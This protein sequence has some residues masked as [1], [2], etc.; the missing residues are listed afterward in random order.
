[1]I[2]GDDE[3]IAM[4]LEGDAPGTPEMHS[5]FRSESYGIL[6]TITFL[7]L[8]HD[9][10][11][12][13]WPANKKLHLYCDNKGLIQRLNNHLHSP[14]TPREYL[15]TDSDV[16]LQ[17]L[18]SFDALQQTGIHIRLFHVKGHQDNT[19]PYDELSRPAQLN[20]QAD[21]L[22][23]IQLKKKQRSTPYYRL[24]ASKVMLV[25]NRQEI[26]AGFKF[27]IR[28]AY[29]TPDLRTYM[30]DK[31]NWHATVPDMI[32][33]KP[34]GKVL[35]RLSPMNST[36]IRKWIFNH[37]PTNQRQFLIHKSGDNICNACSNGPEDDDHI[38]RCTSP[39]AS[40]I[41]KQWLEQLYFYLD[42]KSATHKEVTRC[43]MR[44]ISSWF[45]NKEPPEITTISYLASPTLRKAYWEQSVIGWGHFLR[46]RISK[47][48]GDMILHEYSK[49]SGLNRLDKSKPRKHRTPETWATGLIMTNWEFVI[50]MWENRNESHKQ[51]PIGVEP[52]DNH[53]FVLQSALTAL[54]SNN[55]T[56]PHDKLLIM[57]SESD[58]AKLSTNQIKV[59]HANLQ[60][61]N[62]INILENETGPSEPTMNPEDDNETGTSEP[63]MNP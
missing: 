16:E 1:M 11:N 62:K 41:R 6:G 28:N 51:T 38:I 7:K 14:I 3:S 13:N 29:L 59:W 49:S 2:I 47:T 15:L 61:L 40:R 55:I 53:Y 19:I 24:P 48:W 8:Q 33:W 27:F 37:L 5:A 32:W 30:I 22:A 9:Y 17:I 54:R 50:K 25:I 43:I 31:F 10:L 56:N 4:Q 63:T 18:W 23:T 45:L 58:I 39:A 21:K 57:K 26:T 60:I 20:V 35:S 36:R 42:T 12:I 52:I 44:G 46:G 34:H